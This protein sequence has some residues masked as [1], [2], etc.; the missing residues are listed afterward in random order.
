M[1]GFWVEM[2]CPR[3]GLERFTIKVVKK[4]NIPADTIKPRIRSRPE[5]GTLSC[6]VV[7]RDV[8][9]NRMRNY[10]IEYFRQRG[11]WESVTNFKLIR[12]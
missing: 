4:Y 7:G 2:K 11:I 5:S 8:D 9:E 3:H 12:K 6:L 1:I 10:L